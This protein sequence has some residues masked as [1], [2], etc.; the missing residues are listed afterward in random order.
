M[1]TADL[2]VSYRLGAFSH[3][4]LI[5]TKLLKTS[6]DTE[7]NQFAGL[8]FYLGISHSGSATFQVLLQR[9]PTLWSPRICRCISQHVSENTRQFELIFLYELLCLCK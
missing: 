8:Y 7:E 6:R 9:S 4:L 1:G 2:L 5:L 3:N